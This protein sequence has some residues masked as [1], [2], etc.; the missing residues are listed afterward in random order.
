MGHILPETLSPHFSQAKGIF[1]NDF[2][3]LSMKW[4][5]NSGFLPD[6]F[7][8]RIEKSWIDILGGHNGYLTTYEIAFKLLHNL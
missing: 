8:R 2:M 3:K 1:F 5:Q 6:C 4:L 7:N